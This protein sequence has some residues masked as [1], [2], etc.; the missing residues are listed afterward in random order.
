[1]EYHGRLIGVLEED[2]LRDIEDDREDDEGGEAQADLGGEG[3]LLVVREQ[4]L[5]LLLEDTHDGSV[6]SGGG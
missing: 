2:L 3:Q 6:R 5:Q 1:M 4:R